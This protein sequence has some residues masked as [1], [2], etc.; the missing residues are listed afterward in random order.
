MWYQEEK[1]RCK[2]AY[3]LADK[4]T[5]TVINGRTYL[6]YL[7]SFAGIDTTMTILGYHVID[8]HRYAY[9]VPYLLYLS[10]PTG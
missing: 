1:T 10:H 8:G 7:F 5:T 9:T 3:K 4:A 2:E 6:P